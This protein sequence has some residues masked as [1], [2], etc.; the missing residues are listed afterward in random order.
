MLQAQ[1]YSVSSSGCVKCSCENVAGNRYGS[2][3]S[4]ATS[5]N[6]QLPASN[7]LCFTLQQE[8]GSE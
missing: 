8:G 2:G 6:M 1:P 4:V 7:L 5:T 3:W